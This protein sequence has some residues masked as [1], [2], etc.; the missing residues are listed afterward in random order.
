MKQIREWWDTLNILGP[1]LE[2]SPKSKCWTM[3]KKQF[4]AVL[5]IK[6]V[7]ECQIDHM[8]IT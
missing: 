1:S 5:N 4:W 6:Y 8:T 2:Y 3:I 7:I